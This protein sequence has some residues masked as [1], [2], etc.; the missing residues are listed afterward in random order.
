MCFDQS[1]RALNYCVGQLVPRH[2]P[3]P[4]EHSSLFNWTNSLLVLIMISSTENNEPQNSLTSKFKPAE[5]TALYEFRVGVMSHVTL[6]HI[7]SNQLY[8]LHLVITS[9]DTCSRVSG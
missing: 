8:D 6:G 2:K 1:C 9:P 5:W 4:T 3:V 7:Q